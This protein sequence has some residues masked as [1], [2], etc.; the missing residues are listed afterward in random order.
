MTAGREAAKWLTASIR[1]RIV[2][3]PWWPVRSG[4]RELGPARF[5]RTAPHRGCPVR[6]SDSPRLSRMPLTPS[7][8]AAHAVAP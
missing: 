8:R 6:A 4:C 7:S 5:A 3:L 1:R 2:D